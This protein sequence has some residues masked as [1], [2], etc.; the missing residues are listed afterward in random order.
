MGAGSS[1]GIDH[2][3]RAFYHSLRANGPDSGEVVAPGRPR[4]GDT[5]EHLS[6]AVASLAAR[7]GSPT[8]YLNRPDSPVLENRRRLHVRRARRCDLPDY[9]DLGVMADGEIRST[10]LREELKELADTHDFLILGLPNDDP[11]VDL[12]I[13]G[14]HVD[15]AVVVIRLG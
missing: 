10:L 7:S 3:V 2:D 1:P 14:R 6:Y 8:V 4:R 5:A 15:V 13:L 11:A 9:E 12:P